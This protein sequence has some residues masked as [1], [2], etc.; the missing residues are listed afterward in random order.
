[1]E[2]YPIMKK[3]DSVHGIHSSLLQAMRKAWGFKE[4]ND[5]YINEV[6]YHN[7]D[8]IVLAIHACNNNHG[9]LYYILCYFMLFYV[10]LYIRSLN[11]FV[12]ELF[13]DDDDD[14]DVDDD[15]GNL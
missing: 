4:V 12:L 8:L 13:D 5:E 14:D 10:V 1:M 11:G 6:S 9:L 3:Y 7:P 15:E 2:I